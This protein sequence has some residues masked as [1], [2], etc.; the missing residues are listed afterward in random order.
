MKDLE[1]KRI[2]IAGGATGM[3]A[4][5]ARRL[6]GLGALGVVGDVY[7][8][9]LDRL[10][11][12]LGTGI[13]TFRFDLS[14]DASIAGL[15]ARCVQEFG[16]IDGL[17]ITGADTTQAT[18]SKD[19]E[20]L[21]MDPELWLRTY[22]INTIGPAM[23]MK[24][25]IP[26]MIAGGGGTIV[27]VGSG[28]ALTGMTRLPAYMASKGALSTVVRHVAMTH[29]K[30]GIR[31]NGVHPGLIFKD[32]AP[33]SGIVNDRSEPPT[34]LLGRHGLADDIARILAF[35]LSEE[36]GWLTGQIIS[37]NGGTRFRE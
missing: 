4:A 15:V 19:A 7:Q 6:A 16:G 9:G 22:R 13:V 11:A 32:D 14:D 18:L 21:A 5:L 25:A 33:Q 17:A 34:N 8:A 1:G 31:C 36:S 35:L 2:I 3:G 20:L 30:D 23:V 28:S 10:K 26:H 27:A 24:A 29:G 37:A 12:D